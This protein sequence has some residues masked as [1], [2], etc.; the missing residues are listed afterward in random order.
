M[1][2]IVAN[3]K[4]NLDLGEMIAYKNKLDNLV[5]E[6]NY[7]VIC[8]GYPYLSFFNDANYHLGAQNVSEYIKGAYTGEVS[9]RDLSS[10]DVEFVIVG[11]SERRQYFNETEK[12]ILPK[13]NNILDNKMIPIYC[14]GET[15]EQ[16]SRQKTFIVLEKQ[17]SNIYNNLASDKAQKIIIAYEPVWAIGSGETPSFKEIDE[18]IVFIKNFILKNYKIDTQVL[19]GGSVSG[20]NITDLMSVNPCD[21]FLVGSKALDIHEFSN[22]L[23]NSESEQ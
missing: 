7:V 11:H 10:L 13:I 21:G 6:N 15:K 5:N 8:P 4:L 1:K 12:N 3:L 16:K 14:I 19:Y 2:M 22:I 17:I 18:V 20:Q 23:I 9:A